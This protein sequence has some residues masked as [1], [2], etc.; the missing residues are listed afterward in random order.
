MCLED[1]F[2]QNWS[3]I[4]VRVVYCYVYT[5]EKGNIRCYFQEQ[6]CWKQQVDD[7]LLLK[8]GILLLLELEL[9]K[10]HCI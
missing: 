6:A 8:S 4:S 1:P 9:V 7:V 3:Q 5:C 10:N 2:F